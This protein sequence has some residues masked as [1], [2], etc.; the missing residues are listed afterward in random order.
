MTKTKPTIKF[1]EATLSQAEKEAFGLELNLPEINN[2]QAVGFTHTR[3]H[4]QGPVT[5]YHLLD[6][7]DVTVEGEKRIK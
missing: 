1:K 5:I 7:T 2:V 6:G 4:D 3:K